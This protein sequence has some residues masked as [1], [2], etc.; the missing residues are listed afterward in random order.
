MH[1]QS[2]AGGRKRSGAAAA[3]RTWTGTVL[4]ISMLPRG[5]DEYLE[6]RRVLLAQS[7]EEEADP[8]P[9][10]PPAAKAKPGSAAR[11]S[12]KPGK[13]LARLDRRLERIAAQAAELNAAIAEHAHDYTRLAER[14]AGLDTLAAERDALGELEWLEAAEVLEG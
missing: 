6:R 14:G 3:R 11:I 7:H 9:A 1:A 2:F 12:A 8:E 4:A 10:S 13:T 5:V